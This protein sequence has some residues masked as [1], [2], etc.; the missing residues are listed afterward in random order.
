MIDDCS[1]AIYTSRSCTWRQKSNDECKE[2]KSCADG[3]EKVLN[4]INKA[5]SDIKWNIEFLSGNS[6]DHNCDTS[7]MNTTIWIV[8]CVGLGKLWY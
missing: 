5:C 1:D 7:A 4:N 3:A 8:V 2:Y 6:T